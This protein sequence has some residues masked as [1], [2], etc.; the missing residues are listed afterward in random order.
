[1]HPDA[2]LVMLSIKGVATPGVLEA[3]LGAE[4][5]VVAGELARLERDGSA[6]GSPAGWRLSPDG[7]SAATT[8]IAHE[9]ATAGFADMD[10]SY[11]TFVAL[12]DRFKSTIMAWQ[13]RDVGGTLVPNDHAD[14]AYDAS[15]LSDIAAIHRDLVE[16][17]APLAARVPRLATYRD[18]F[19]RALQRAQQGERRYVAAPIIESYHTVWFEF[20]EDLIRLSGKTRASEAA[21]GRGA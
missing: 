10:A 14:A 18:R 4:A 12:N 21:A 2:V 17:L 5:A 20:H 15:V 9:R 6:S 16:A 11:E 19:A 1:M 8:V 7:R 13:L 3:A